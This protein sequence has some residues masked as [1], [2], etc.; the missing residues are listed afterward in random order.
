MDS[1]NEEKAKL[2]KER[3]QKE[4]EEFARKKVIDDKLANG[5]DSLA[6]LS[7]TVKNG[8]DKLYDIIGKWITPATPIRAMIPDDSTQE[9]KKQKRLETLE[10]KV[11]T[12]H[13]NMQE[14]L[15]LLRNKNN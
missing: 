6:G 9:L 15:G 12:L 3:K 5:I 11:D 4:E 2:A 13:S 14:I 1:E 8:Q 7:E 10:N